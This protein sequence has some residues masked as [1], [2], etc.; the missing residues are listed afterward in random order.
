MLNGDYRV[1]VIRFAKMVK[2]ALLGEDLVVK[3]LFLH[4]IDTLVSLNNYTLFKELTLTYGH[5]G[6]ALSIGIMLRFPL[7]RQVGSQLKVVVKEGTNN[8]I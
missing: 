1:H 6:C 4:L 5:N 8:F 7:A 3:S 2:W